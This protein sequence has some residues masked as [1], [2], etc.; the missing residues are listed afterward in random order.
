MNKSSQ[1]NQQQIEPKQC[2]SELEE[3]RIHQNL[4]TGHWAIPEKIQTGGVEDILFWKAP[5]EI[6]DL[7]LY[8]KKFQRKKAFTS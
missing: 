3:L 7:S 8:P 1:Y 2:N 4:E 6:L 5:L